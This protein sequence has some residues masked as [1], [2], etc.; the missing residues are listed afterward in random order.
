LKNLQRKKTTGV[1]CAIGSQALV[2]LA[3]AAC[4]CVSRRSRRRSGC[5]CD[6]AIGCNQLRSPLLLNA[7]LKLR[8]LRNRRH[9]DNAEFDFNSLNR[10]GNQVPA[11]AACRCV[12]RRFRQSRALCKPVNATPLMAT[13]SAFTRRVGMCPR[14][15]D[16]C[17]QSRA[18][19]LLD[20]ALS[21][22]HRRNLRHSDDITDFD[23]YG[24]NQV[25][26]SETLTRC[27]ADGDL[28][29]VTPL[30]PIFCVEP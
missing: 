10:V 20:A 22:R 21:L 15:R 3:E 30:P 28:D 19:D 29:R 8:H 26:N 6:F 23:L 11:S 9:S 24:L 12:S 16:C 5:V 25:E 17:N 14:L 27:Y 2:Q 18:W 4:R 7:A 13:D 1:G